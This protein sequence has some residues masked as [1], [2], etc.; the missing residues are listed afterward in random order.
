[1]ESECMLRYFESSSFIQNDAKW[2]SLQTFFRLQENV[3]LNVIIGTWFKYDDC[4]AFFARRIKIVS[5]QIGKNGPISCP[6]SFPNL[7]VINYYFFGRIKELICLKLSRH[8]LKRRVREA[9]KK[10]VKW[11]IIIFKLF[12]GRLKTIQTFL[13]KSQFL[14]VN[15]LQLFERIYY[16]FVEFELSTA[17][18]FYNN[19]HCVVLYVN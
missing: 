15:F 16:M 6:P 18:I 8:D 10:I 11:F 7:T 19:R 13:N 3:P 4:P 9:Y 2:R 14:D 1:M 12:G 5:N 17:V